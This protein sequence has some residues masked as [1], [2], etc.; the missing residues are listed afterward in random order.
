MIILFYSLSD[1]EVI[2]RVP[3]IRPV[4]LA[5]IRPTLRPCDASRRIVDGLPIC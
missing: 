5:A 3:R 4:R 1:F 2:V